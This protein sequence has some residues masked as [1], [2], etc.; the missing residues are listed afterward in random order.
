MKICILI[1][2]TTFLISCSSSQSLTGGKTEHYHFNQF[3]FSK[4]ID[5]KQLTLTEAE[6]L[7][8]YQF[9]NE[10]L[11]RP[12][13][14]YVLA[15][16]EGITA[17]ASQFGRV[18]EKSYQSVRG[19]DG[20]MGMIMY[21]TFDRTFDAASYSHVKNILWRNGKTPSSYDSPEFCVSA[22]T[23]VVWCL[24]MQ[25][26]IKQVSQKKL[27]SIFSQTNLTSSR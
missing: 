7:E 19:P 3:G 20:D 10:A 24:P 14:M 8:G 4:T 23:L 13:A 1:L 12:D 15:F 9:E 27:Y 11:A 5:V 17:Y 16:Y 2:M 26:R 22:N 21:M 6:L 25:S 18:T